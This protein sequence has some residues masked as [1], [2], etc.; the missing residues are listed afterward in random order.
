[1]GLKRLGMGCRV[2]WGHLCLPDVDESRNINFCSC[3]QGTTRSLT[4]YTSTS[5]MSPNIAL[6]PTLDN[7]CPLSDLQSSAVTFGQSNCSYM[8]VNTNRSFNRE[9]VRVYDS[10]HH[11]KKILEFWVHG[12]FNVDPTIFWTM[13]KGGMY[14]MSVVCKLEKCKNSLLFDTE[15]VGFMRTCK[16]D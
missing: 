5:V 13:C 8:V 2:C 15:L 14:L 6:I 16:G 10:G 7:L 9:V 3:M 1:M 4:P 11:Q 12:G